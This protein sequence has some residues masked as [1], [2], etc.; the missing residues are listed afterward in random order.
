MTKFRIAVIPGDG[1]GPE[2]IAQTEKVV[3]VLNKKYNSGIE[4]TKFPYSADYF[5][6]TGV[7][8]PD[9]FIKEV[10]KNYNAILVGTL[11]DP[12]VPDMRHV[13]EVILGLRQKL[14]LYVY[15]QP[16]KLYEEWLCPF[17]DVKCSEVDFVLFREN[18]EGC[19]V[20][21]GG[22]LK[23]NTKEEVAIQT[24]I[25]TYKGIERII[26][27][28]FD[29]CYRE[30]K[31]NICLVDK[32]NVL[33]YTHDLWRRVFKSIA[34]GYQS[35][36]VNYLSI[37]NAMVQVVKNPAKFDVIVTC[38]LFGDIMSDTF[39]HLQG[40]YGLAF[41]CNINPGK[42]SGM[43]APLLGSA[44]RHAGHNTGNPLGAVLALQYLLKFLNLDKEA[45]VVEDAV[46][47][48]LSNHWT[49]MDLGGIIGTEEVGNYIVSSITETE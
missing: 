5:L 37:D 31:K 23:K 26:R 12:R 22:F 35:I 25:S 40:G 38:N 36:A 27:A 43:F 18:S 11:G 34:D 13:R 8:L 44:P 39:A 47:N 20:K 19:Y 45:K 24:S 32:R 48:T 9:E 30:E 17:K 41:Y 7:T 28:A 16:V 2:I 14:D 33:V 21:S 10:E 4:L 3:D 1:I 6:E 15:M 29:F 42:K 46:I 49:T